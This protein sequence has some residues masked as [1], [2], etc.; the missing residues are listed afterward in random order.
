MLGK[1]RN[2]ELKLR[3]FG[4]ISSNKHITV[5]SF[6]YFKH[7]LKYKFSWGI[8]ETTTNRN[9]QYQVRIQIQP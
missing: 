8:L 6:Q 7:F 4:E 5:Q 2:I 1:W 3:K 9:I